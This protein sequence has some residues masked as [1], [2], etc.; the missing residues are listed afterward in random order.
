MGP[1]VSLDVGHSS[2]CKDAAGGRRLRPLL[3]QG[4]QLH[5]VPVCACVHVGAC[6]CVNRLLLGGV[7]WNGVCVCVC[8][9]QDT[10]ACKG[11]CERMPV[12]ESV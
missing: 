3:A 4:S 10:H 5:D 11:A 12:L 6:I 9:C 7:E 8:V 1:C 2:Q